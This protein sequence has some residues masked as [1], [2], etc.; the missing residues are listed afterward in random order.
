MNGK[1][2]KQ[3]VLSKL[4]KLDLSDYSIVEIQVGTDPKGPVR[5]L[6]CQQPFRPGEI[7]RR[8]KSPPDPEYGSYTVGVHSRC[9]TA[10]AAQ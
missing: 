4:L 10:P 3:T 8:L 5:C 9:P 1:Q 2:T 6:Q 7:W